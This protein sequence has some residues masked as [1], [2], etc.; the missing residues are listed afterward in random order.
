VEECFKYSECQKYSLFI[1]N[2]KPTFVTEYTS[3][4][5]QLC[6]MAESLGLSLAFQSKNLDGSI[7]RNCK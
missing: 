3:Y 6:S 7:Y 2:N 1:E 5:G 4:D